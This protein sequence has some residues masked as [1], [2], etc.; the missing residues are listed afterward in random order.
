[1]ATRSVLES[2]LEGDAVR[3]A[4]EDIL[5]SAAFRDSPQLK[6]FLSYVV[7]ETLAG[8]GEDIKGYSI[9]TLAL[10]R[11]ESFDPQIDPIVRVQAG[12]VRQALAEYY[13]ANPAAPVWIEVERGG[14]TPRFRRCD[15][16]STAAPAASSTAV[17]ALDAAT[18][19]PA[20]DVVARRGLVW[21]AVVASALLLLI[22]VGAMQFLKPRS[23]VAATTEQ[24]ALRVESFFPTLTVERDGGIDSSELQNTLSR[25]RDAVARFD[26]LV[27]VGDASDM[28]SASPATTARRGWRLGLRLSSDPTGAGTIRMRASLLDKHDQHVI[29]SREFE[30]IPAGS[31]GDG[32]RSAIVRTI[33]TSLAQ[34]YGVIHA[35]VRTQFDL[36]K[37]QSDPFGCIVAGLDYWLM[38]D[39]KTHG[40]A[41]QCLMDKLAIYPNFGALHA[42]LAYLHLEEFRQGYNPM[43]GDARA[44]AAESARLAVRYRPAS[45]RSHQALLAALFA[46]SDMEG[47]W[48]AAD[49]ALALN[50]YDTE[51]IADV[52]SY[53]VLV[54]NYEQGLRFLDKATQLNPAPPTWVLTYRAIALYMLGRI[55]QSGPMINALEGSNY[56]A[57]MMALVMQSFQYKNRDAGRR[58]LARFRSEHPGIAADPTQFLAKL[59]FNPDAAVRI[60]FDYGRAV[61]WI[62]SQ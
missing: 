48:R 26:D 20:V 49:D 11:P 62:A 46:N 41:R 52:G 53:H 19:A 56:P 47:A 34:P 17:R 33:A 4:L 22:G 13:G 55:E 58:H 38:N 8:R 3:A 31:E 12:R 61:A 30:P 14:Y 5:A 51:I 37:R 60:I 40:Q 9:A 10:G 21:P 18:T 28:A 36:D 23:Q 50:P 7:G 24:V 6:S 16:P 15:T 32:A 42:Q 27:L 59:N 54:G 45:A 57:A 43:S 35:Y 39:R 44:R 29:W 2:G 1:V 25:I